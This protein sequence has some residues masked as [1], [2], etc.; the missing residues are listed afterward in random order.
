MTVKLQLYISPARITRPIVDK[1]IELAHERRYTVSERTSPRDP[2]DK[3]ALHLAIHVDTTTD[4]YGVMSVL[5]MWA[6]HVEPDQLF[7]L[8]IHLAEPRVL[9]ELTRPAAGR[10]AVSRIALDI[11]KAV[12][13]SELLNLLPDISRLLFTPHFPHAECVAFAHDRPIYIL[14]I[15]NGGIRRALGRV[16]DLRLL[17]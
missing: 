2:N 16:G 13:R 7:D 8:T 10:N 12:Q 5:S 4:L 9:I 11:T 6:A 1:L 17:E 14:D 3:A 15:A